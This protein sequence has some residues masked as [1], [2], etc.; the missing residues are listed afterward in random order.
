[1]NQIGRGR[2]RWW[3][4]PPLTLGVATLLGGSACA[5]RG[6]LPPRRHV[7]EIS[8]MAFQPAVL[9]LERGDTVVW[10][11]RDLVPHTVTAE[12]TSAWTTGILAQGQSGRYVASMTGEVRYFCELHPVMK[13]KLIAR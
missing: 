5:G 2:G 8:G 9:E 13:G 6:K 3:F 1:V 11:N 12:R 4:A 10:V 7:V